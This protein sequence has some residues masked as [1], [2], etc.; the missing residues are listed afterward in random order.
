[1]V[2]R[3]M[4]PVTFEI[5]SHKLWQIT[6][7]M[8]LTLR[9]VSGSLVAFGARDYAMVLCN[10]KGDTIMCGCGVT[11]H[12]PLVGLGVKHILQAYG[13]DPGIYEGDVF[14]INDT[15]ICAAHM[16][17]GFVIRPIHHTGEL[18]GWAGTMIHLADIGGIPLPLLHDLIS[19]LLLHLHPATLR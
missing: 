5:L 19:E 4:D 7:E 1:M 12:E 15:Q 2:E 6:D 13:E 16:P 11:I 17:D 14:F 9:R 18:V 3:K 8:G 10:A